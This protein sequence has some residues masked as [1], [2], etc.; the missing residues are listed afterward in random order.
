MQADLKKVGID[1]EIVTYEWGEYLE[2]SKKGEHDMVLLGWTGDNGDPD[3]FLQVLL[4]CA[5]AKDGTNRAR[6][7]N[8]EFEKLTLDAKKTADLAERTK[9]YEQAQVVFKEEAPWVTIAHSVVFKPMRKEVQGFQISPF[10]HHNFYPV[11]L[12]Q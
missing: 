3:N 9:L 8:Q 5:G 2:R 11:D 6:W 10:G 7:C 12:A 1:A 4:G